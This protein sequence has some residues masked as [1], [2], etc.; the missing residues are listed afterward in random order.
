MLFNGW[1]SRLTELPIQL[2]SEFYFAKSPKK[3]HNAPRELTK[4][5][6]KSYQL[7]TQ[8]IFLPRIQSKRQLSDIL[9]NEMIYFK[10]ITYLVKFVLDIYNS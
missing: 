6:R 3:S 1:H 7:H 2:N 10:S 5:S 4:I 9:K 8:L